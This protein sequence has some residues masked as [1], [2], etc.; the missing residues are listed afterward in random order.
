MLSMGSVKLSMTASKL[1][2]DRQHVSSAIEVPEGLPTPTL[3]AAWAFLRQACIAKGCPEGSIG[4][5]IY[6][7]MQAIVTAG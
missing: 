4:M 5:A 2:A 6:C 3:G 1:S 7:N